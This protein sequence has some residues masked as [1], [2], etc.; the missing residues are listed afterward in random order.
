[1]GGRS[2]AI[3][4]AVLTTTCLLVTAPVQAVAG[5]AGGAASGS[6]A[7]VDDDRAAAVGAPAAARPRESPGE[8]A[9]AV[10]AVRER[11]PGDYADSASAAPAEGGAWVAF[12]GAAPPGARELLEALPIPV[13]VIE[14]RG[15][16]AAAR[17][18]AVETAAEALGTSHDAIVEML[19]AGA[20]IR[21][22]TGGPVD[23]AAIEA[24]VRD[25]LGEPAATVD[26]RVT[27]QRP[28]GTTPLVA[29][30]GLSAGTAP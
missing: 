25:A 15:L 24:A 11:F 28:S 2:A 12:R 26:V 9:E 16:S 30:E 19:P 7:T 20:V 6:W 29:P 18:L 1:V 23:V 3:T 8:F 17:A 13:R 14:D 10:R 22:T 21:V 27:V 5:R 4:A